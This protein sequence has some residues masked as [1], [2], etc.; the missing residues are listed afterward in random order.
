MLLWCG[1]SGNGRNP[2]REELGPLDFMAR[3]CWGSVCPERIHRFCGQPAEF[4]AIYDRFGAVSK[5]RPIARCVGAALLVGA[6]SAWIGDSVDYTKFLQWVVLTAAVYAIARLLGSLRRAARR[7]F[8][9]TVFEIIA[10]ALAG[11]TTGAIIFCGV[12]LY[13]QAAWFETYHQYLLATVGLPWMMFS[14]LVGE[15]VYVGITSRFSF[16]DR[17]REWLGRAG[18][19]FLS[20]S[21]ACSRFRGLCFTVPICGNT[22]RS[23]S[24]LLAPPG[25]YLWGAD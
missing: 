12:W 22:N 5:I 3:W 18:G 19:Y 20:T 25:Y 1:C 10:W 7:G 8:A 23:Y 16:G 21:L 11:A 17:D 9:E 24:R 15:I 4:G 6:E 14:F 2:D 13:Y